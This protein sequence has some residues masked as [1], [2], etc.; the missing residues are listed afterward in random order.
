MCVLARIEKKN[1]VTF[2][3]NGFKPNSYS[4]VA[5]TTRCTHTLN[6]ILHHCIVI[7]FISRAVK[8]FPSGCR[9]KAVFVCTGIITHDFTFFI[10]PGV[11]Q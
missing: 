8:K 3:G 10:P 1:I 6:A 9:Y 2:A 11:R 7:F 4:S 5:L